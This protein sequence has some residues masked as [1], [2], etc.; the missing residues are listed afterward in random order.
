M[1]KYSRIMLTIGSLLPISLLAIAITPIKAA[2]NSNPNFAT[3]Q[4]VQNAITSLQQQQT[5][6]AQQIT[7]LQGSIANLQT[8][9]SNQTGA[10]N[11][12]QSQVTDQTATLTTLQNSLTTTQSQQSSLASQISALQTQATSQATTITNLQNQLNSQA[13]IISSLQSATP[14]AS[15]SSDSFTLDKTINVCF[16][17]ANGSLRVLQGNSCSP[18]VRWQIPVKCVSGE[19]CKP[20][21]PNDLYYLNNK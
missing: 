3:I 21:N 5:G 14:P 11:T 12:L 15:T 20:D 1:T 18:D 2:P 8:Q 10:I 9:D 7:S 6:Q 17:V 19:P 16:N 13:T 4:D